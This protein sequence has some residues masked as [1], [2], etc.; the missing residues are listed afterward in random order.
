MRA[1]GWLKLFVAVVSILYVAAVGAG[2]VFTAVHG[3]YGLRDWAPVKDGEAITELATDGAASQSGLRT[4]D[5]ILEIDDIPATTDSNLFWDTVFRSPRRSGE[6]VSL[7]VRRPGN[8]APFEVDLE[9]G[10]GLADPA[11]VHR[12]LSYS[13]VGLL[14][15]ACVSAVALARPAEAAA[16]VLLI[17][18]I[19][20]AFAL[21]SA[22]IGNLIENV[23]MAR[24]HYV[25]AALTITSALHLSLVFPSAHPLFGWNW[26]R[27]A[28]AARGSLVL[29]LNYAIPLLLS[30][31]LPLPVTKRWF[32]LV[33][34]GWLVGARS[35]MFAS[36][37]YQSTRIARA[38]LRWVFWAL[39]ICAG[40]WVLGS[41]VPGATDWAVA[42]CPTG[43]P[44]ECSPCVRAELPSPSSAIAFSRLMC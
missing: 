2:W 33:L 11:N 4:G 19:C 28:V 41:V 9:L 32:Y 18:G 3:D 23:W 34:A 35:L 5:V 26:L 12:A 6:H 1:Q 15:I 7:M 8:D 16:R 25:M 21:A 43:Q 39:S 10:S 20:A 27:R 40:A 17:A 42:P 36:Y 22:V 37:R 30:I 29:A 31:A 24:V 44:L 13:L 14:L 38:Q